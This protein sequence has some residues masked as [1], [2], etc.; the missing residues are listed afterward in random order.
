MAMFFIFTKMLPEL[1]Q[2]LFTS[3]QNSETGIHQYLAPGFREK[4][5]NPLFPLSTIIFGQLFFRKFGSSWAPSTDTGMTNR[6]VSFHH[7]VI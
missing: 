5:K 3:A 4:K 2:F 1:A 7:L 6:V